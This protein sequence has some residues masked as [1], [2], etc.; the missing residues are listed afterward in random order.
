MLSNFDVIA[1]VLP[2]ELYRCGVDAYLQRKPLYHHPPSWVRN[3]ARFF[4][5]VCCAERNR[6]QLTDHRTFHVLIAAVE[7]YSAVEQWWTD[8]FV[9]IPDHWH[10]LISFRDVRDMAG[11]MRGWKR[12]T[13]KQ[14]GIVWQ[15]GFFDHRLRSK[16][17]VSEKWNYILYNPVRKGLV[18]RPEIWPYLWMP[19][20]VAARQ[21]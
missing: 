19:P 18:Q 15:D 5:T 13:A 9:A 16:E 11:V 1:I 7:H 3:G 14:T 6:P 12:Y 8:L 17:S 2:S 10:A 4:I 20:P 21:G